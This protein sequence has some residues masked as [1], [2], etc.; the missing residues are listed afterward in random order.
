MYS[1]FDQQIIT[2]YKNF[3]YIKF[4]KFYNHFKKNNLNLKIKRKLKFSSKIT[5]KIRF[6]FY[7]MKVIILKGFFWNNSDFYNWKRKK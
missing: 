6:L 4:W 2:I 5:Q 3:K 1:G 7:G